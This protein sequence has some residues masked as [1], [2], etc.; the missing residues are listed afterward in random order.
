MSGGKPS[1]ATDPEVTDPQA[2]TLRTSADVVAAGA[3]QVGPDAPVWVGDE[4]LPL[5]EGADGQPLVGLSPDGAL[6]HY[7]PGGHVAEAHRFTD[8]FNHGNAWMAIEDRHGTVR[9]M[10]DQWNGRVCGFEK[11]RLPPYGDIHI[12]QTPSPAI[13]MLAFGGGSMMVRRGIENAYPF[14]HLFADY[15]GSDARIGADPGAQVFLARQDARRRAL[16]TVLTAN[17]LFGSGL[18]RD[19]FEGSPRLAAL[20]QAV[21]RMTDQARALNKELWI[22][23]VLLSLF[24]GKEDC[25]TGSAS[26]EYGMAMRRI[27]EIVAEGTGQPQAPVIVVSQSGGTR[28]HGNSNVILA[29][30]Q[31]DIDHWALGAVVASPKYHLALEPGSR[32]TLTPAAALWL[33][34]IEAIAAD[35]VLN[36]GQWYCP[37][38][39]HARIEG[40]VITG[41]VMATTGAQL[42]LDDPAAHGFSLLGNAGEARII[43]VEIE[44]LTVRL[45]LSAHPAGDVRLAYAFGASG[46]QGDDRPANRGSLRD[47]WGCPSLHDPSITLRRHAL[48]SAVPVVRG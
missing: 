2:T 32:S 24:E 6:F 25:S 7:G 4:I 42:V 27:R 39:T 38:L 1:G 15:G 31:L 29:E 48:S 37:R 22:D 33:S 18:F 9:Y 3:E 47:D 45:T 41:H 40:R 21:R 43:G 34:E 8:P 12:A 10:S 23:R 36:G 35:T 19:T 17:L 20:A 30:A 11:R 13:G 14:H 16:P 26:Y 28:A 46:D 44:G 5:V